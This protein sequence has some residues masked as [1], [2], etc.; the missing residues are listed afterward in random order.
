[1]AERFPDLQSNKLEKR[2]EREFD[3]A[4]RLKETL[5]KLEKSVISEVDEAT[6]SA[7]GAIQAM[8]YGI[9]PIVQVDEEETED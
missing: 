6:Q 1:M 8:G 2:R 7:R 9:S 4:Q 3:K 5:M